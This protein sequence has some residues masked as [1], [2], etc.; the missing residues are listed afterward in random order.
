MNKKIIYIVILVLLAA[1]L[2]FGV[3]KLGSDKPDVSESSQSTEQITEK[4]TEEVTENV[5]DQFND[6][7]KDV[8]NEIREAEKKHHE[9]LGGASEEQIEETLLKL[10]NGE[11]TFRQIF[12]K[13][14]IA[15]DSLM[16]GLNEYGILDSALLSTMVS[17]RLSDLNDN[18]PAIVATNP[19]VLILHY[20]INMIESE[21]LLLN[22]FIT[23]YTGII[24]DLKDQL[25]STRIIVSG[26]F[27][28]D[29]SVATEER[30]TKVDNYNERL[31]A[32]CEETEVEFL[33]STSAFD[34][35]EAYY[36]ADGIHVSSSFYSQVWLPFII[37][38]KGIIG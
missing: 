5:L 30:F 17:A 26:L 35:N 4:N 10:Q 18:I 14:Y 8:E 22:N 3:S 16:H 6:D 19:E 24:E 15:G 36:G 33:D 1:L 34:G 13:T 20:G 9:Q 32:M 23:K 28:V 21:E 38:S 31:A 12:A 29:T 2:I 37:E 25:P 27:P 11:I 7:A